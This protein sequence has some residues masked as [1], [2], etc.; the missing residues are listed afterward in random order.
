MRKGAAALAAVS[1]LSVGVV[2]AGPA[3]LRTVAATAPVSPPAGAFGVAERELALAAPAAGRVWLL[4][5]AMADGRPAAA[6]GLVLYHAAWGRRANDNALL[7]QALAADGFVVLA[8]DDP[9]FDTALPA[10]AFDFS[11]PEAAARMAV[12]LPERAQVGAARLLATLNAA[13][14]HLAREPGFA[15]LEKL[16]LG[17]VGY[18]FGGAVALA[19]AAENPR[20]AAVVNL[21]GFVFVDPASVSAA[22]LSLN[23]DFLAFRLRRPGKPEPRKAHDWPLNAQMFAREAELARAP[24]GASL[25]LRGTLHESF[26]TWALRPTWATVTGYL[27]HAIRLSPREAYAA[28]S[29]LALGFLNARLADEPEAFT[30]ALA[31]HADLVAIN[32]AVGPGAVREHGE[33]D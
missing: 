12:F 3:L 9:S 28:M 11:S 33:G 26:S 17:I 27:R 20:L 23:S 5:P 24:G 25:T 14:A 30:T 6:K 8:V 7:L 29:D 13:Q 2:A 4:A 22:T 19:A 32:T 15:D 10:P 31:A 18:S 1:L 21:D 16:P